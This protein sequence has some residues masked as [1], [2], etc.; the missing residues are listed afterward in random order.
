MPVIACLGWGSLIWNPGELPIQRPW[1]RDGPMAPVEFLRQS[2][3]GR[4][5]L[6]L[7]AS[8]AKVRTLWAVMNTADVAVAREALRLRENISEE[9]ANR[10]IRSWTTGT[11]P[12]HLIDDLPQWSAAHGVDAVV[13]TGLGPRF[14]GRVG[15]VPTPKQVI[16]HLTDLVGTAREHAEHYI[17]HT[18][19]QIDTAY[20]RGIEAALHWTP[21]D[22]PADDVRDG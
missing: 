14:A 5:T 22:E 2:R 11:K 17:R 19:R 1:F 9:R 12:P 7:H 16:T 13:W 21:L 3:D 20:R 10:D 15:N 18:P 4:M 6:V 8:A